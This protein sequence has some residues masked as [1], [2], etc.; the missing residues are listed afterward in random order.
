MAGD[1][2]MASQPGRW[3]E[4]PLRPEYRRSTPAALRRIWTRRVPGRP[5]CADAPVA[6]PSRPKRLADALAVIRAVRGVRSGSFAMR[7][8]TPG[9]L[10]SRPPD[11]GIRC[12]LPAAAH[13]IPAFSRPE[14]S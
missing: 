11:A 3:T 1:M 6:S 13:R 9:S 8:R 12:L 14:S 7:S 4:A 2:G 10:D 5:R